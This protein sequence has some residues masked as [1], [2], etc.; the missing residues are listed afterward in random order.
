RLKSLLSSAAIFL[1][2]MLIVGAIFMH[3]KQKNRFGRININWDNEELEPPAYYVNQSTPAIEELVN[4]ECLICIAQTRTRYQNAM[5]GMTPCGVY[6]ISKSYWEDALLRTDFDGSE[7]YESCV[8]D[9]ECAG[10]IVRG[11]I[12]L[13][14]SDCNHDG[15]IGCEDHIT[16]HLLGPTG[17]TTNQLPPIYQKRMNDCVEAFGLK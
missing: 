8:L 7:D 11:Y 9:E 5:C 3:L 1:S 14:F 16:L 4:D 13:Y 12:D 17:C 6:G 10:A 2:L 15:R